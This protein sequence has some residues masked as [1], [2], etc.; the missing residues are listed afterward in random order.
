MDIRVF[1]RMRVSRAMHGMARETRI[2]TQISSH[3]HSEL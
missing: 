3:Y 1:I 2:L